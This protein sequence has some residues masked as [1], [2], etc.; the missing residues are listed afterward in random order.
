MSKKVIKNNDE[1][2]QI[3]SDEQF[4][5]CRQKGTEPAF[6]GTYWDAKETGIYQCVC[7]NNDLFDSS[8]KFN[9]G[10]GWPSFY[11]AIDEQQ[12]ATK[13]DNSLFMK[14]TEVLC[15]KCDAHLGHVFLDGPQPTGQRFCINSASLKLKND[16][17]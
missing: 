6:S 4:K 9:S 13:E 10:T 8:T 1:W 14:R 16:N 2:H 12:V 15:N 5:I 11:Q 17:P 7:C 3:L